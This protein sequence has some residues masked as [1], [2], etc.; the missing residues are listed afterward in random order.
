MKRTAIALAI[1]LG[2]STAAFAVG[3]AA[4]VGTKTGAGATVGTELP[5]KPGATAG[6]SVDTTTSTTTPAVP[7]DPANPAASATDDLKTKPYGKSDK[8]TMPSQSEHGERNRGAA[9]DNNTTPG[10]YG[11]RN[12]GDASDNNVKPTR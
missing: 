1:V 12:R 2:S 3:P 11:E 4:D 10:S 8:K 6:T 9:A 7:A 5:G